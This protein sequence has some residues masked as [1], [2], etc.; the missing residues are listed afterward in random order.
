[1]AKSPVFYPRGESQLA[2]WLGNFNEVLAESRE[3]YEISEAMRS[4]FKEKYLAFLESRDTFEELRANY[5]RA[6]QTRYQAKA[7][8]IAV[9]TMLS[10]FARSRPQVT[11]AQR[12]RLGLNPGISKPTFAD[13][14]PPTKIRGTNTSEGTIL[15]R[16]NAGENPRGTTDLIEETFDGVAWQIIGASKAA[17]FRHPNEKPGQPRWYRVRAQRRKVSSVP[18]ETV[19][20]RL[21]AA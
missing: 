12:Q 3:D 2:T 14:R 15:L 11:P 9:M 13:P 19:G 7:E 10:R 18:S 20:I 16:W 17:S 1:M 6:K 4:E 21:G 5:R 8:V